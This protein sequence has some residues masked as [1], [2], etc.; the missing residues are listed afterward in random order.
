MIKNFKKT[1]HLKSVLQ[2]KQNAV[3]FMLNL[4]T[5][6]RLINPQYNYIKASNGRIHKN[7]QNFQKETVTA[8]TNLLTNLIY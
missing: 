4:S 5:D 2:E 3:T 1:V 6:A 8:L 7:K